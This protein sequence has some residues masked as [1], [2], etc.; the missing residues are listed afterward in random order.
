[1]PPASCQKSDFESV[2]EDSAAALRDLNTKN[3]P[4]YQEKLKQLKVKR[5]WTHEQFITEA[6]PLVRDDKIAEYDQQTDDVLSAMSTMGQ[7]GAAAKTPDCA[8]LLELR[9]HLK[10]LVE[11]QNAKWAY[12]F[13]KLETELW[14]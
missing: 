12:M 2:V 10:V 3:K 11:T 13:E 1:M 8:V 4:A 7:E 14:K 5:G 9:A 6:A